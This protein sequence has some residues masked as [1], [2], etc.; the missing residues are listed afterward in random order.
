MQVV[1]LVAVTSGTAKCVL[2]PHDRGN[3]GERRVAMRAVC[4]WGRFVEMLQEV[5]AQSERKKKEK[6]KNTCGV[7][8]PGP[9]RTKEAGG[10]FKL[11][12]AVV[13]VDGSLGEVDLCSS[14]ECG[15]EGEKEKAGTG[16]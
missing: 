6:K 5:W 9:A 12:S 13:L 8:V 2:S 7:F 11:S 14:V 16:L 4:G 3:H 10:I 15:G 1:P